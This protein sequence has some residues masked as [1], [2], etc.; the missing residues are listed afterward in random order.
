MSALL[1]AFDGYDRLTEVIE[2]AIGPNDPYPSAIQLI[3]R[4]AK[5]ALQ[6]NHFSNQ[7][8]KKEAR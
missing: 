5:Q 8:I 2:R 3:A 4:R 6:E 1:T 7:D